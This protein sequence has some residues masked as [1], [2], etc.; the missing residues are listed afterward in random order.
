MA[1]AHA[2]TPGSDP[3]G[4]REAL[5][6]LRNAI[7]AEGRSWIGTPYHHQASLK[8][9]GCD[10]IGLV[11]GVWRA[12]IGPEPEQMPAYSGDWGEAAGAESLLTLGRRYFV[13]VAV[14]EMGPGDVVVFRMRGGRIAKHCGILTD[15]A[16]RKPEIGSRKSAKSAFRAP[17]SDFRFIHAQEG[18]PVSEVALSD[19]WRR[20]IA[21]AFRFPGA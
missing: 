18:V 12:V 14:E 17:S 20:R 11:R 21:G 13:P 10:C 4:Q 7:V 3:R 16:V 1:V 8:S 15:A 2:D 19:W 9:A 6:T 5:P